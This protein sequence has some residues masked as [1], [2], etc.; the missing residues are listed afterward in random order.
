MCGIMCPNVLA[1]ICAH[2]IC[3]ATS[4]ENVLSVRGKFPEGVPVIP[5]VTRML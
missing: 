4:A 3:E 2:S 5:L 1:T